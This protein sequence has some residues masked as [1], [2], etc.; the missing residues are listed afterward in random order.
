MNTTGFLGKLPQ[1]GDFVSGKLPV[2]FSTPWNDWAEQLAGICKELQPNDTASLWYRLPV[3]RFY[4]SGA[5]AGENAWIGVTLPSQDSVG[6]LFPFCMARNINPSSR[7]TQ[8][9]WQNEPFFAGLEDIIPRLFSNELDFEQLSDVLKELDGTSVTPS[10]DQAPPISRQTVD[11]ALSIRLGES[12]RAWDQAAEALLSSCCSAYSIWTTSPLSRTPQE[13]LICEAMP[14]AAACTSL[15]SG[16]FDTGRWTH[17]A[18]DDA[19]SRLPHELVAGPSSSFAPE[20]DDD[21][22]TKPVLIKPVT[23]ERKADI[24]ELGDSQPNDVPWDN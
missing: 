22:D 20:P 2:T 5:I 15:F 7:A 10:D 9:L 8:T 19:E 21:G 14:S 11:G 17:F 16:D 13:N 6:R 3:Y 23:T 12:E 24:L 1:R 18:S 4:L